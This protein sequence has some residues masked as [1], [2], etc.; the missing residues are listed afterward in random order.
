MKKLE[1][2]KK[3]IKIIL[4]VT[5]IAIILITISAF[6]IYKQSFEK[7]IETNAY[8]ITTIIIALFVTYYLTERKNDIR[9]LNNKI[10]NIC[11]D[12]QL[13]IREEYKVIPSK[14]NKEKVL[15]NIRYISNKIHI[16]EQLSDKNKE[17]KNAIKY[18]KIEHNKYKE[19]VT[20]NFDQNDE[21]FK[22]EKRQEKIKSI[23]NRMDNKID[24]IMVYLYTGQV[25]TIYNETEKEE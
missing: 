23:I 5:I 15:I 12:I 6:N 18:I 24:E 8:E 9:K 16:L 13:Y 11:N 2:I 17:I 20:D 22:E 14:Q 19:F 7:F 1:Y 3:H 25:P 4:I 10:E 21:Y